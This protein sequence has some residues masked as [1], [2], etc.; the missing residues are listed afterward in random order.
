M[1]KRSRDDEGAEPSL[2]IKA[3]RRGGGD[4]G[5]RGCVVDYLAGL[6]ALEHLPVVICVIVNQ[7]AV[8]D[9]R[10]LLSYVSSGLWHTILVISPRALPTEIYLPARL[11]MLARPTTGAQFDSKCYYTMS[12]NLSD[13]TYPIRCH[14]VDTAMTVELPRVPP[15][16]IFGPDAIIQT[17]GVTYLQRQGASYWYKYDPL[18]PAP[19]LLPTTTTTSLID[20]SSSSSA[21]LLPPS[22][23]G[24]AIGPELPHGNCV[25]S[26]PGVIHRPRGWPVVCTMDSHGRPYIVYDCGYIFRLANATAAKPD[27]WEMVQD[28]S[29]AREVDEIISTAVVFNDMILVFYRS[30]PMKPTVVGMKSITPSEWTRAAVPLPFKSKT[31]AINCIE[32][33]CVRDNKLY[34]G[35]LATTTRPGRDGPLKHVMVLCC[36][37]TLTTVSISFDDLSSPH[38]DPK[39]FLSLCSLSLSVSLS[40]SLI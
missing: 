8:Y 19:P 3:A 15:Q 40:L 12:D 35:A 24:W 32:S 39:I 2:S 33:C 23:P 18:K 11:Y 31:R 25:P 17:A 28:L 22:S 5:K 38:S 14:D 26:I 20:G 37:A 36:D 30:S 4:G 29:R 9:D 7:Y 6:C 34:L 1:S 27:Q 13:V 10:V 21:V 16:S